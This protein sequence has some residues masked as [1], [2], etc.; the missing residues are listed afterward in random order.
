MPNVGVERRSAPRYPMVFSAEVVELPRGAKF[1]AR[2]ADISKTGCYIDTLNPIPETMQVRLRIT[3][4]DEIF[5]AIGRVVYVSPS[6]GMGIVFVEV[7]PEQRARLDRWFS[8]SG[9]EF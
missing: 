2:T 9:A 4:D 1:C 7:E 3:H 8:E 5:E 6:L